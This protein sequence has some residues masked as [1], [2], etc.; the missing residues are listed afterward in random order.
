MGDI[1]S[2]RIAGN[3][4]GP[5]ILASAEYGCAVAGAK[6]ILV[7]GHTHCGA[8]TTAVKLACSAQTAASATGCD[9]LGSIVTDIQS[10]IDPTACLDLQEGEQGR[11]DAL[12]NTVTRQNVQRA[13]ESFRWHSCSLDKLVPDQRI[14][15]VGALYQ[16]P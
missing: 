8:V 2:I 3:V 12:I 13:V 11:F 16:S 1:F 15:I 10:S 4:I 9:H 6:L 5:Q 7:V 14:A